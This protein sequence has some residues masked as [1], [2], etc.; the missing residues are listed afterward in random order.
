M[1]RK[2]KWLL[3]LAPALLAAGLYWW[4][5]DS[6]APRGVNAPQSHLSE[7][8]LPPSPLSVVSKPRATPLSKA[9]GDGIEICGV[10][11]VRPDGHDEAAYSYVAEKVKPAL[12]RWLGALRNSD[13]YRSR[14]LGLFL[15]SMP[16]A[17]PERQADAQAARDE[18]LAMAVASTDPMVYAIGLRRCAFGTAESVS[19]CSQLSPKRWAKLDPDNAAPWLLVAERARENKDTSGEAAAFA[20]AGS[21]HRNESYMDSLLSFAEPDMPADTTPLESWT[22]AIRIFGIEAASRAPVGPVFSYCSKEAMRDQTVAGRCGA[23]AE[24][25]ASKPGSVLDLMVGARLGERV[26]WTQQRLRDLKER[27]AAYLQLLSEP[28]TFSADGQWTCEAVARG[29]A[30]AVKLSIMGEVGAAQDL[31]EHSQETISELAQRREETIKKMIEQS[32]RAAQEK[33]LP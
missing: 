12:Q 27:T 5:A 14:A 16:D 7:L 2:V 32:Q 22:M 24:L 20:A 18:L 15:S 8:E 25:W 23:L 21:A 9:S 31:L 11:K 4:I 3:A 28:T 6:R 10:G 30:M 29:N 1:A 26:G 19:A 33:P 17:Q 13:D